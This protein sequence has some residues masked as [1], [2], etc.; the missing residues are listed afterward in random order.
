MHDTK[1]NL[2]QTATKIVLLTDYELERFIP[3][4]LV[5]SYFNRESKC[6]IRVHFETFLDD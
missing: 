6:T 5:R 2:N 1:L 3:I 4:T